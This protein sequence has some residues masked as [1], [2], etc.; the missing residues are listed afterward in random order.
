M[1]LN[2]MV[3]GALLFSV[4]AFANELGNMTLAEVVSTVA[5]EKRSYSLNNFET[6]KPVGRISKADFAKI[7][8]ADLDCVQN[9]ENAMEHL[10]GDAV[11][12]ISPVTIQ[13]S[14]YAFFHIFR[15]SRTYGVFFKSDMSSVYVDAPYNQCGQDPW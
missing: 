8:P 12:M 4:N 6:Q 5:N 3:I 11:F 1:K 2:F 10:N 9:I 7:L 14:A 13:G 15:G